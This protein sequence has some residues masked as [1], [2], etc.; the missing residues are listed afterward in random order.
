MARRI[1]VVGGGAAGMGAAGAAKGTDPG[2][3]III[4]TEYEDAAYSPC[5]IPYVHGK[6]I[7]SFESL[8][9]ATKQQYVDQGIDIRYQTQVASIN[10]A[11]KTV[12]TSTGIVERYDA[13][14]IATGFTYAD[15]EVPGGDL[16]G[17]YYVKNI[18][19]AME[20]DKILDTVKTA[21]VDESTPLGAEMVTALAHRGIDTHLV[22]PAPWA[23]SMAT[24][25]D[26]AKPVED[27]WEEM[28]AHLHFNTKV[29]E[30]LGSNGRL[31]AVATTAGEIPADLAG[32]ATAKT[33]NRRR[34]TP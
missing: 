9:M 29:T 2:A 24:D 30:F 10:T 6:E 34:A 23:L 13:L 25:P 11:S 26:I 7:P 21:V 33:A 16:Q 20:W 15:P 14:V 19:Q 17:L 3:E 4:I 1:V 18:R 28:G 31:R 32:V 8:F 12:T 22:E 27:S 5:G